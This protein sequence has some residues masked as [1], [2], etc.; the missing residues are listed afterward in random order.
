MP[1]ALTREVSPLLEKCEL[2]H[3]SRVPIDIQRAKKQ[4][5]KYEEALEQMGFTIRRLTAT[6]HL[7][8]GVFV[9]DTAVVF[10]EFAII[11][12]PGAESR[13]GET[14]SMADVLKEYRELYYIREPGILDG[15]DVLKAGKTV[16]I[17]ITSRTNESGIQQFKE[18]V[19]MFGYKVIP[20]PVTGCLHL[21]S[22]ITVLEPH[23]LL[24]NPDWIHPG[25]FADYSLEYVHHHEPY[26]ANVIRYQNFAICSDAYPETQKLLKKSGY[27]VISI[28]QSELE[29]AEAG[30]TC[31]SVIIED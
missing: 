8:D 28:D 29:K 21:K 6:P 15:G 25:Y 13:R 26:G 14:E 11:T 22:G 27:D 18:I 30:L 12:R 3:Q 19:T 4:H 10:P 17:G 1:I 24:I 31:C 16:Y 7:P 9:E 2:T 5:M 20:I 23:R